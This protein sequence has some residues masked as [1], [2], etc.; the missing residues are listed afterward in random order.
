MLTFYILERLHIVCFASFIPSLL[1]M[2]QRN[3]PLAV[4]YHNFLSWC[5]M[6]SEVKRRGEQ[7]SKN[8]DDAKQ[9]HNTHFWLPAKVI[10]P[11]NATKHFSWLTRSASIFLMDNVQMYIFHH[12]G[13]IFIRY[14]ALYIYI[15]IYSI[16]FLDVG[17][18]L[19]ESKLLSLL[20]NPVE[21][22]PFNTSP[23]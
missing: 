3:P 5:T 21:I 16:V 22:G 15:Y 2:V 4:W 12:T 10:C 23:G 7:K 11:A 14:Y 20:L 9:H 17:M 13:R 8:I 1:L 19:S 18:P 6:S